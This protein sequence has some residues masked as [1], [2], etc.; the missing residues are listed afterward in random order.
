MDESVSKTD[1]RFETDGNGRPSRNQVG[2]PD[3]TTFQ[4]L[5]PRQK[6]IPRETNNSSDRCQALSS[7]TVVIGSV[8]HFGARILEDKIIPA[9][10]VKYRN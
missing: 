4:I 10:A 2:E 9:A 1:I 5:R 3:F 6:W 8:D 7:Y